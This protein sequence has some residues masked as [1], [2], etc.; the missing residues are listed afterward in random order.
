VPIAVVHEDVL[1]N[2][3]D[4]LY[5]ELI[6]EGRVDAWV[7]ASSSTTSSCATPSR[8][9]GNATRPTATP[10]RSAGRSSASSE[11]YRRLEQRAAADP[12]AFAFTVHVL[13]VVI[14]R[15]GG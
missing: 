13:S 10:K 4:G 8:R 6:D 3:W 7:T 14:A 5:E 1:D 9:P 15:S 12:S 2:D 11:L